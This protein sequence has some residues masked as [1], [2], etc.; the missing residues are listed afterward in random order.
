M[1]LTRGVYHRIHGKPGGTGSSDQVA[2]WTLQEN[3]ELGSFY[4]VMV[5]SLLCSCLLLSLLLV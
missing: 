5:F 1:M 2:G 3:L 4:N